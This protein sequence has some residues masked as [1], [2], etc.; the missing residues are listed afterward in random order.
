MTANNL[1]ILVRQRLGDMQKLSLSDEELL[2]SLNVA[3]DRLS[4]ELSEAANPELT[5]SF[6]I[7]NT[8]KVER[9]QDF[10]GLCGQFPV[11]FHQDPDGIKVSHMNPNYEG[12]LEV[13]YFANRPHVTSLSDTIPFDKVLQ[14]RQL[15]TYT[16]YDVKSLTG[17]VKADDGSRANG[18]SGT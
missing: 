8:N 14:Q 1:L 9:P 7:E 6:T 2:M 12:E 18:Q 4:Q 17:E 15:V 3:I 16:V 10:I 11:V 5:K 13:R